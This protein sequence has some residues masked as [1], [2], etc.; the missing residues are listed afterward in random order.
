MNTKIS[1]EVIASMLEDAI[2]NKDKSRTMALIVRLKEEV[3]TD[4]VAV[5]WIVDP[6]NLTHLHDIL[7]EHLEVP[8]K[9]MRVSIRHPNRQ[10]RAYMFVE[11]M[12]HG[13]RRIL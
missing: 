6:K 9:V 11:A 4:P 1:I 7:E 10:R 2:L 5:K 8:R 13:V 12:E 3:R